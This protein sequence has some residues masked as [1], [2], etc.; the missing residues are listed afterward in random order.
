MK[1][2]QKNMSDEKKEKIFKIIIII[3]VLIAIGGSF[4]NWIM[5]PEKTGMQIFL[6]VQLFWIPFY[7]VLGIIFLG[8][9]INKFFK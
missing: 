8:I 3:V 4:I 2:R 7:I 9:I 5:N 1:G 6:Q